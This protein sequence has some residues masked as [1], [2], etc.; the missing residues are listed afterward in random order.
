MDAITSSP[1]EPRWGPRIEVATEDSFHV[2]KVFAPGLAKSGPA[3]RLLVVSLFLIAF[4]VA[5]PAVVITFVT[6]QQ[7]AMFDAVWGIVGSF[8]P[9]L[10]LFPLG[11]Y[12]LRSARRAGSNSSTIRLGDG[13]VE[14]DRTMPSGTTC[15]VMPDQFLGTI[16]SFQMHRA[17]CWELLLMI[18]APKGRR[19]MRLQYDGSSERRLPKVLPDRTFQV[20]NGRTEEELTWLADQIHHALVA[21]GSLSDA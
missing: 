2:I 19:P 6:V 9:S 5:V 4:A 21:D 1:P 11:L 17:I 10:V 16:V 7:R 14:I 20:V 12:V 15:R 13:V 3:K 8:L 18:G